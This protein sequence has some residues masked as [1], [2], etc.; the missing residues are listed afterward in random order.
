[1]SRKRRT[2]PAIHFGSQVAEF[3]ERHGLQQSEL[4]RILGYTREHL[5]SIE[6]GRQKIT[7]PRMFGG[8]LYALEMIMR[9]GS[10]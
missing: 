7:H 4:A 9:D 10:E 1:M 3:R 2:L 8:A 5:N 6:R